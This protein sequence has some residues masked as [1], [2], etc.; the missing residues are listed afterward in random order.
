R[1]KKPRPNPCLPPKPRRLPRA[2]RSALRRRT[3]SPVP[4]RRHRSTWRRSSGPPWQRDPEAR[5]RTGTRA[6]SGRRPVATCRLARPASFRAARPPARSSAETSSA[7]ARWTRSS[8]APSPKTSARPTP[9]PNRPSELAPRGRAARQA[10][11]GDADVHERGFGRLRLHRDVIDPEPVANHRR[12]AL[13]D[14][15]PVVPGLQDDVHG[16]DVEARRNRPRVKVV[17]VRD[18]LHLANGRFELLEGK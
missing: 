4:P 6:P 13:R 5:D 2:L 7:S 10:G 8:L 1:R 11:A 9:N 18:A 3:F 17:E 14:L 12:D 15:D 16:H